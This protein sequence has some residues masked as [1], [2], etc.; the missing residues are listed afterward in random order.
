MSTRPES[1]LDL[2]RL[3]ALLRRRAPI[4][5]LAFLVAVAGTYAWSARQPDEYAATSKVRLL[6]PNREEIFDGNLP[7][8]IDPVREANTQI[9]LIRSP[10]LRTEVEEALG[11]RAAAA[12]GGLSVTAVDDAD[13]LQIRVTSTSPDVARDGADAYAQA[14]VEARRTHVLEVYEQRSTE[15]RR[16]AEALSEQIASMSS[17]DPA[18]GGLVAQQNAFRERAAEFEVDAALRSGDVEVVQVASRPE[19]P[20]APSPLRDAGLAGAVVALLGIGLVLLL[21]RLDDRLRTADEASSVVGAPVLGSIPVHDG[22]GRGGRLRSSNK[23][24]LVDLSSP[25]AEAY[26][27]LQ[28]ALRFS[29]GHADRR[30]LAITSPGPGEGKTTITANLAMVLAEN[31]LN[32][33]VVSADLRKPTIGRLFGVNER[34]SGGLT[35]VLLDD[36]TLDAALVRVDLASGRRMVILPTGATPPNPTELLSAPEFG[37]VVKGLQELGADFVL[38]DC[39][40]VL[41]VSDPLAV[42]QHVDGLI[43]VGL[44]GRTHKADLAETV[45]RLDQVDATVVG[46]IVNGLPTRGPDARYAY[47][48]GY[49]VGEKYGE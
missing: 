31:G 19:A 34:G 49:G 2:R 4:L 41:A 26:Q 27:G 44:L 3:P 38:V 6:N 9:E 29:G 15:L 30:A 13:I 25:I 20:F 10:E 32:V 45:H 5:L 33:A 40:P 22:G 48:Y 39:P 46:T 14:Y 28:T 35:S 8:N 17:D 37:K 43:V 36:Q 1:E 7:L 11:R 24:G 42:S 47:R 23:G 18:R 12:L 16:Q 21:D